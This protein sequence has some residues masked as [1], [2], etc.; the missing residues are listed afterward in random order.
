MT[1]LCVQPKDVAQYIIDKFNS[2]HQAVTTIKLQKLVYY[3]QAWSLVW[4]DCP[5]FNEDFQAWINGPVVRSLFDDTKGYYYCPD[6]IKD[7]NPD[8][9]SANQKDTIDKVLS[10]YGDLTSSELV[11]L[12]HN[13]EPWQK[14]RKDF[15]PEVPSTASIPK[16]IIANYY[17]GL[18]D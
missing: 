13:E 10:F 1:E 17:S 12:S 2:R 18:I 16:D 5:L 14:A 6:H 11:Q 8:K 4:D 3:S 15:P 9:L 7:A